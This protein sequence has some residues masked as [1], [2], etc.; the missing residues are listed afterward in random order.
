[1]IR[2][3]FRIAFR[4]SRKAGNISLVN[5][6]GLSIGLAICIIIFIYVRFESSY[7]NF[8]RDN[9]RIFRVEEESN[10]HSDRTRRARCTNFI[11]IALEKMDETEAV[12]WINNWRQSTVRNGDIAFKENRIFTTTPGIFRILTFKILEGD[13]ESQINRPN[14]VVITENTRRRYFGE[15]QAL[16]KILTIDT[17]IFE[18]VGVIEEMPSNSHFH[19]DFLLS[20]TTRASA[21]EF[22]EELMLY[23]YSLFT[24]I[25]LKSNVDP[26]IFDE[27]VRNLPDLV[28]GEILK[29]TGE[30]I[31]CFLEPVNE[32]HLNS[33]SD[34]NIE[35]PGNKGFLY[36]ISAIGILV[37]F[38]TCFNYMNLSTGRFVNRTK[39]LGVRKTFGAGKRQLILQ[40]LGESMF[41]VFIA[42]FIAMAFVETGLIFINNIIQVTL[43][44]PYLDLNFSLFLISLIVFTGLAAGSYP[45]FMLSSVNPVDV[46]KGAKSPGKSGLTFRRVLV[47]CQFMIS[48]L[49]IM[50]TLMIFRQ[51]NFMRNSPLGF[52]K[53][54]KLVLQLP[55][56]KV[57]R[58]NCDRVK[59]TFADDPSV[60]ATTLSSSVPGRWMYGWQMW[61][62]GEK[63]TNTQI[64]DCMQADYDFVRLYG[65][66]LVAGEPFDPNLSRQENSGII[67]NEA[68]VKVFGWNSPEEALSKT[69]LDRRERI[70]GVFR[71]YH[72]RG[73]NQLIGPMGFFNIEDD[74]RYITI[75]FRENMASDVL[76][77]TQK[78]FRELFPD[79][80][81]D[82]FFL[83][84]D[85]ERQ[86]VKEQ[87]TGILV[88]IFTVFAILIACL[89]LYGMTA[90]T[91]SSK[92]HIHGIMKVNGASSQKIYFDILRE[93]MLWIGLAFSVVTP[94]MYWLGTKWLMQ[95]PYHTNFPASILIYSGLIIVAITVITISLETNKIFR[96]NPVD[97]IRNE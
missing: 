90:Y 12:G 83:D 31:Q 19:P 40:F 67:I 95:F 80:A 57:T 14:T 26:V 28:A 20:A 44:V 38:T 58:T 17:A 53:E 6:L 13:P 87:T 16:G 61:P 42:Y 86:Y 37:L 34:E 27:K 59:A 50:S 70:R 64:L 75:V 35:A 46:L 88:L 84:E 47:I 76:R 22:P 66:E 96:L 79:A 89:G 78:K 15:S 29:R 93:F 48:I 51:L 63:N 82:Y 62:S 8:H 33:N 3:Y 77:H 10:Q 74:F 39:E 94:L 9:D 85:F 41:T 91:L 52:L 21:E 71:D 49:L 69:L 25:K 54:Q 43:K 5:I 32:I 56:G 23:G 55:T 72:F 81:E 18:V 4:I 1:M 24:F 92:K 30:E 97:I 68:T 60:I 65:L 7:D 11:G 45:A 73:K 2:H 36:L